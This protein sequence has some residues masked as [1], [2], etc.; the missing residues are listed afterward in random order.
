[1]DPFG[2]TVILDIPISTGAVT[3]SLYPG[4]QWTQKLPAGYIYYMESAYIH[5]DTT[6]ASQAAGGHANLWY[7]MDE[8]GNTIGSLATGA[9]LATTG[10]TFASLSTAYREIDARAAAHT[11]Y[12]TATQS[13][14]GVAPPYNLVVHTV[15]SVR[16]A[17][18]AG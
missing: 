12:V 4:F 14:N 11:I 18:G 7:L 13:G 6:V 2:G 8:D 3:A 10:T 15:W 9:A 16:R 17:G 5:P 1:M